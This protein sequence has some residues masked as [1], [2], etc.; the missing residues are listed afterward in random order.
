MHFCEYLNHVTVLSQPRR[1]HSS[2]LIQTNIVHGD[3]TYCTIVGDD[4]V[5]KKIGKK[6]VIFSGREMM[7]S[8][9]K[10][11]FLRGSTWRI[12]HHTKWKQEAGKLQCIQKTDEHSRVLLVSWNTATKKGFFSASKNRK[13]WPGLK[14]IGKKMKICE[15]YSNAWPMSFNIPFEFSADIL[16]ANFII[17]CPLTFEPWAG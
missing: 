10:T 16:L 4:P 13:I 14:L 6:S 15:R 3:E 11:F 8:D 12:K 5:H 7:L 2:D 17:L 1:F 9:F